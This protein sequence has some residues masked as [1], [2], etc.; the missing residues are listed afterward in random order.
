MLKERESNKVPYI[1][2]SKED[3]GKFKRVTIWWLLKATLNT[4]PK[5]Y[6]WCLSNMMGKNSSTGTRRSRGLA[7]SSFLAPFKVKAYPKVQ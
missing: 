2:I 5:S 3:Y 7:A 1:P 4:L 6:L